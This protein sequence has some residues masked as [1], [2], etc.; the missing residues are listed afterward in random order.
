MGHVLAIIILQVTMFPGVSGWI[1]FFFF[2][3]GTIS[4]ARGHSLWGI[5]KNDIQPDTPR[6]MAP[7]DIMRSRTRPITPQDHYMH[8]SIA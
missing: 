3:I 1:S 4:Y 5:K 6:T 8:A 7:R 2:P